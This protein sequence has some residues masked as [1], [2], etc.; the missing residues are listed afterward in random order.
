MWCGAGS[1]Y[2]Q[3]RRLSVL[4][5]HNTVFATPATAKRYHSTL[6]LN[7]A[8]AVS[9]PLSALSLLSLPS[10]RGRHRLQPRQPPTAAAA[11]AF[12]A[13]PRCPARPLS[14]S[15]PAAASAS[16][17]RIVLCGLL[18]HARHGVYAAERELGQK[19]IVDVRLSLPLSRPALSG[20]LSDSVDYGAVYRAVKRVVETEQYALLEELG[21]HIIASVMAD[22]PAVD[23]VHVRVKKP[24][25]A[26]E[27]A[28]E[29]LGVEMER[30]RAQWQAELSRVKQRKRKKDITQLSVE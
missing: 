12:P 14:S 2:G 8:L 27:G 21:W 5:S 6:S 9:S 23:S 22:W 19:F 11:A 29:W 18:F 7:A 13:L 1:V 20:A 26:V 17:D 28:V 10:H 3:L 25:V 30:S 16:A 4:Y 15:S 24:H